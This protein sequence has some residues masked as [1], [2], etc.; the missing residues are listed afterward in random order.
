MEQPNPGLVWEMFTAHRRSSA[1]KAAIELNLFDHLGSSL[2]SASAIAAKVNAP[3]RGVRI[4]CDDLA[5][6][7]LIQK[8]D[9]LYQHT[10]TS[11]IFLDS[12]S[13]ASMA[14]MLPFLMTNK[15]IEA[16]QRLTET[17]RNDYTALEVPLAGEEVN[18]WVQFARSM[19]PMM[20]A[21]SQFIAELVTKNST[22][23]MV[24]DVAA[25]HWHVRH[26]SRP[27]RSVLRNR[28]PRLPNGSRSHQRKR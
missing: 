17:I 23:A 2:I 27:S 21:A 1:I 24:L 11:A 16:S 22:P 28:R 4:L 20:G 6:Q 3:E 14:P 5:I 18:E 7:G 25:S 12:K 9:G 8:S 26:R 10:P 19:Q 15:I 13:P